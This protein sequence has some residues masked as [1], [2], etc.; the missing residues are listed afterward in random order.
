MTAARTR[1]RS[2]WAAVTVALLA[3]G[4]GDGS[5]VGVA[6]GDAV[7]NGRAVFEGKGRCTVCHTIGAP[8]NDR[9]DGRGPDLAGIGARA[10]RRA[11]EFGLRGND[12]GTQYLVRSITRPGDDVPEGYNPMP[13][14]W[15]PAGLSDDDIRDLV[16]YLGSLGGRAEAVN[17]P[18]P[19]AWLADRRREY[20]AELARFAT[21]DPQRGR[22]LFHDPTGN[23]GCIKCH[24]IDG[25]GQDICPDL[26]T[27]NRVQRPGYILESIRDSSAVIV[28]GYR[29][30]MIWDLKGEM[31][32]GLPRAEDARS[33]TLVLNDQGLT[34]VLAKDTIDER[35]DSDVSIMPGNITDLISE[36]ELMDVVAYLLQ[37]DGPPADVAA[38][39]AEVVEPRGP[40]PPVKVA[41]TPARRPPVKTVDA[42]PP[43]LAV[44]DA[45]ARNL[46]RYKKAM[47]NGD[48]TIGRQLYEH[49]CV[50]C[51]GADGAG[52]GFNAV[53]LATKPANHT[54]D[55]R[56]SKTDDRLLH[57]VIAKGGMKTG[58]SFLMPAWGGTLSDRQMWDL[59]AYLRTLHTGY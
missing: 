53:N 42:G 54:D 2:T 40:A 8:A 23:A 9:D 14:S 51:H 21:G 20:R 45:A 38:A 27:V 59:V 31:Y 58:R 39:P 34:A 49:Y 26:S 55:R 10:A 16:I 17:V 29:Q 43:S 1:P 15:L 47:L 44:F 46:D 7:E 52:A 28:R 24:R 3:V 35:V 12:S 48:P 37:H 18:V 56:M 22:A 30:Q 4:C 6:F 36:Q 13:E 50:M 32:V 19:H 11:A 25:A 5:G 33:I 57:G 41:D